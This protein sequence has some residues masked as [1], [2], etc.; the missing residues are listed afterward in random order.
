MFTQV[1]KC[2]KWT[3]S[4]RVNQV[5]LTELHSTQVMQCDRGTQQCYAKQTSL[6]VWADFI[7]LHCTWF[8]SSACS[9]RNVLFPFL[10]GLQHLNEYSLVSARQYHSHVQCCT[11]VF[12]W[13]FWEVM[14]CQNSYTVLFEKGL[15]WSQTLPY[16]NH[17]WL[18][19]RGYLNDTVFKNK[20][21]I[22]QE[23]NNTATQSKTKISGE[24]KTNSAVHLLKD[25]AL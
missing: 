2:T 24:K 9:L 11:S 16:I 7:W 17:R 6:F 12:T 21:T 1:C 23:L 13:R 10:Q 25:C 4:S 15:S 3:K 18:I 5:W 19:L 20:H 22:I 8:N 14:S